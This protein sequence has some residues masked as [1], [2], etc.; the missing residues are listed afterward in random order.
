MRLQNRT[1]RGSCR[2]MAST[3]LIVCVGFSSI[4]AQHRERIPY[5][6]NLEV[7]LQPVER[8]HYP[9]QPIEMKVILRNPE[10]KFMTVAESLFDPSRLSVLSEDGEP[11]ESVDATMEVRPAEAPPAEIFPRRNVQRIYRVSDRFPGITK[12]GRYTVVWD[13]PDIDARS[14]S[15]R[16][17]QTYDPEREYIGEFHTSMGEFSVEFFPSVAPKNVKNFIDLANSDFYDRMQFHMIIPGILI[18]AGD[19][20][21]DGMGY[22][23]YRVP[24]EFSRV[25]HLKGTLSMW[26][27]P[28]TVDSGSQF[29]IGLSSQSQ[30]DGNYTVIGQVIK[31]I[32]V[33]EAIGKIPTTEDRGRRPFRPLEAVT[34]EDIII[35]ER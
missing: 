11:L 33:V 17:I 3:V 24:P 15:I 25:R 35:K 8:Y 28:T 5:K 34:I 29:F 2:L 19:P 31:G 21:G 22:P 14:A 23:G 10:A 27:H 7:G 12:L 16:I 6:G 30:F 9:G 26:H 1:I 32:E 18:Q 13:H 4:F 20:K